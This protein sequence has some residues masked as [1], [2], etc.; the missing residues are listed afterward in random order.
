MVSKAEENF[1]PGAVAMIGI[2]SDE[3]S[4]FMK[5]CAKAPAKIREIMYNGSSNS[6]SELG[7][8]IEE[9]NVFCDCGDLKL[10]KGLKGFEQI[11]NQMDR[12]LKKGAHTLS[13]GGDHAITYPIIKAFSKNY[14]GMTILQF[15]AHSDTYDS[16][17]GN[18]Y[19]HASP[20]ARIMEE[21]LV[22][23]LIQVG[24][25]TLTD[26]QK[27]QNDKFGVE[28]IE[29]RSFKH[30]LDLELTGPLYISMDL[31]VLDPAFAPGVSHH[32][33]GGLNIRDIVNIIHN[34]QVPI[35][36]ADIVE[37]NPLRDVSDMTA[38]VATKFIKELSG[39]MIRQKLLGRSTFTS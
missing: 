28:V 27:Q 14:Q 5:G 22:T 18:R 13:L 26:H 15:D 36:G 16:F 17:E 30:T 1:V 12:Y 8:N 23:R 29:A 25:R 4:S 24:I 38:M 32:E 19:S 6:Y 35:V 39:K 21:K 37:Y 34:I 11:E 10:K 20:F 33:P 31:D 3:N 2:P 9:E 7:V